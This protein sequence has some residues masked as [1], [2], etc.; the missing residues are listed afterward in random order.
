MRFSSVVSSHIG[1]RRWGCAEE[2]AVRE[3]ETRPEQE[4]ADRSRGPDRTLTI[5]KS[6]VSVHVDLHAIWMDGAQVDRLYAPYASPELALAQVS[7]VRGK[8]IRTVGGLSL[9]DAANV[10]RFTFF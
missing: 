9:N 2:I 4:P 7:A 6:L 5:S 3:A 8:L 10:S 1:T